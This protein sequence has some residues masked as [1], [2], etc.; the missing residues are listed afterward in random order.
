MYK[1]I[2]YTIDRNNNLHINDGSKSELF[3][4]RSLTA[5]LLFDD[6]IYF[7]FLKIEEINFLKSL[8]EVD[9]DTIV[10]FAGIR[11][12]TENHI[13]FLSTIKSKCTIFDFASNDIIYDRNYLDTIEAH[14]LNKKYCIVTKSLDYK[15]YNNSFFYDQQLTRMTKW[16]FNVDNFNDP[17]SRFKNRLVSPTLD[18]YNLLETSRNKEHLLPSYKGLYL[19]GHPRFHKIDLLEFLYQNGIIKEFL[20]TCGGRY[21]DCD[22]GYVRIPELEKYEKFE[23]LKLLPKKM[24]YAYEESEKPL[25]AIGTTANWS[26]YMDTCFEVIGE[27]EF[28]TKFANHE[29]LFHHISEKTTK[30]ILMN[31]PFISMNLPNTIKKLEKNFGFRF[32]SLISEFNH[33]YDTIEDDNLRMDSIKQKISYLNNFTKKQLNDLKQEYKHLSNE[34]VNIL[35][36]IF[37]RESVQKIYEFIKN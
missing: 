4:S 21:F 27:T 28:F 33:N 30:A 2:V 14:F 7:S 16:L 36:E 34:N 12:I 35:Y 5:S 19:I 10:F 24:D 1:I 20:W 29:K 11:N 32:N 15:N 26:F 25:V 22:T 23:V 3:N 17:N 9:E 37:W 31:V 8:K 6:F 13:E 18:A